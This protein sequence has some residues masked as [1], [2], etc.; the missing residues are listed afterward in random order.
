MPHNRNDTATLTVAAS[1]FVEALPKVSWT[2]EAVAP[3]RCICLTRC[4]ANT[5]V[6][7]FEGCKTATATNAAGK[8]ERDEYTVAAQPELRLAS[9]YARNHCSARRP[10]AVSVRAR[11]QSS[12]TVTR[13]VTARAS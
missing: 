8:T 5:F 12:T 9:K 1:A 6:F 4:C 11:S 10:S 13:L 2:S 3:V 7:P